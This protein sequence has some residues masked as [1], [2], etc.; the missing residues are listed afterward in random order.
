MDR[1]T[2]PPAP[3]C[4]T[5]WGCPSAPS[6]QSLQIRICRPASPLG[7]RAGGGRRG[8]ISLIDGAGAAGRY[9]L[10]IAPTGG[11]KTLAGFLPSLIELP[12][13]RRANDA[14]RALHTLY[15]SPLK[16]LAVD[17][18]RNLEAPDRARWACRSASRPAPA[19]PASPSASA[20]RATARHPA[21]HARAACPALRLGGRA[22]YFE[23]LQLRDPGRDPPLSR[24]KRGDLLSL[25]L[26]RLQAR[27]GCRRVGPL[28]HGARA[29]RRSAATSCRSWPRRDGA[30][31]G[32]P[33][34]RA[35]AARRRVVD[36]LLSDGARALG[37]PHRPARHGARSTTPSRGTRPRW[38]SSTPASR[39]SSP[40]R[41]CGG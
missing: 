31:D 5:Q 39:P 30:A 34:D 24:S 17:V 3:K 20:R 16:A 28:G 21:D 11:G 41:S 27:A 19:T 22:S 23:D 10:L 14:G 18:E 35:A 25:G 33:G 2:F 9:A 8:R 6:H 12:S 40:S 13:G 4:S 38:S 29:G 15:I 32:R 7:S 36:M 1:R 37:R 26:A